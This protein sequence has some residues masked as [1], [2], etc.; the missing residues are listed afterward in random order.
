MFDGFIQRRIT[1]ADGIEI[2]LM[3]GGAGPPL[4]LLH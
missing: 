2:N 3:M 4:L 1:C